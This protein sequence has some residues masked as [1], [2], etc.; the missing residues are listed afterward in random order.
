[1]RTAMAQRTVV[2]VI[3]GVLGVACGRT[4]LDSLF[5][6]TVDSNSPVSGMGSFGGATGGAGTTVDAGIAAN[7]GMTVC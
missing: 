3:T 4:S 2:L 5:E 7:G 6:S 1:M